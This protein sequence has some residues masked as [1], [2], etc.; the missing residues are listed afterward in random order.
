MGSLGYAGT[1]YDVWHICHLLAK[2]QVLCA[3]LSTFLLWVTAWPGD[4]FPQSGFKLTS[5]TEWVKEKV[6][7]PFIII[8]PEVR[9]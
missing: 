9:L 8:R 7:C 2:P 1:V 5:V 4:E 6:T 3:Q